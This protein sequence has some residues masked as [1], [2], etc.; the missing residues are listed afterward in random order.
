MMV[1]NGLKIIDH[2]PLSSL[3]PCSA[4]KQGRKKISL[5]LGKGIEGDD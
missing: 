1:I 2:P 5:P 4:D 3:L